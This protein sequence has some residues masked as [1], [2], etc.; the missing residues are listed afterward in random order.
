MMKNI[1]LSKRIQKLVDEY[2]IVMIDG[3]YQLPKNIAREF[4]IMANLKC[5]TITSDGYRMMRAKNSK[6]IMMLINII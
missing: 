1:N 5:D 6:K 4:L 2:N 3:V